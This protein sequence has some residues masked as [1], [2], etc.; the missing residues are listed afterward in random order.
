MRNG[1]TILFTEKNILFFGKSAPITDEKG[2]SVYLNEACRD[3]P[4]IKPILTNDVPLFREIFVPELANRLVKDQYPLYFALMYSGNEITDCLIQTTND[5]NRA[6]DTGST[7]L[8]HAFRGIETAARLACREIS[9]SND[10]KVMFGFNRTKERLL[11]A[12]EKMIHAGADVNA[13]NVF[14]ETPLS[15]AVHSRQAEAVRLLIENGANACHGISCREATPR[16]SY[17][18]GAIVDPFTVLGSFITPSGRKWYKE[19][20][21]LLK[22]AR[23]PYEWG[24]FYND[25]DIVQLLKQSYTLYKTCD[26]SAIEK[27]KRQKKTYLVTALCCI[28]AVVGGVLSD[29]L[30]A[31]DKSS[32]R[33]SEHDQVLKG[34]APVSRTNFQKER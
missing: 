13:I 12:A 32:E 25:A 23:T 14:G 15:L 33:A 17:R 34:G 31:P 16:L 5:L 1:N 27:M 18:L 11:D 28:A 9:E 19:T 7:L 22:K 26:E 21:S 8:T 20:V 29:Y 10:N 24:A 4:L 3:H 30:R 6:D 2:L